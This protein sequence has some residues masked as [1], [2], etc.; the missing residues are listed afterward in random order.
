MQLNQ[1]GLKWV[2][3]LKCT[4]RHWFQTLKTVKK[5]YL[6]T[7]MPL[8]DPSFQKILPLLSF[9]CLLATFHSSGL[10]VLRMQRCLP[11]TIQH[12]QS[13]TLPDTQ[14]EQ[15]AVTSADRW[16]CAAPEQRSETET[17]SSAELG[18]GRMCERHTAQ[19]EK[20]RRWIK[21]SRKIECLSF[22]FNRGYIVWPVHTCMHASVR[23]SM[24]VCLSSLRLSRPERATP[25]SLHTDA[26]N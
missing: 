18:R 5:P 7:V 23:S 12:C 9:E 15:W 22:L 16:V 21:W 1:L 13:P 14:S 20:R 2:L 24:C 26:V 17:H 25:V 6:L 4:S 11:F 8:I 19:R 10:C 3:K